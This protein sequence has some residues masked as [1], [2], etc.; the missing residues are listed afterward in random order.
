MLIKKLI[1]SDCLK[2]KTKDTDKYDNARNG[3]S[4]TKNKKNE[5]IIDEN[6]KE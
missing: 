4:I 1:G 2:Y 5:I 3:I 6:R